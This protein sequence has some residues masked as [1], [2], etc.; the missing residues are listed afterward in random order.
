MSKQSAQDRYVL[1]KYITVVV[2]SN[3]H[4]VTPHW[5]RRCKHLA[6]NCFPECRGHESNLRLFDEANDNTAESPGMLSCASD[7]ATFG[8]KFLCLMF[9][10]YYFE[11]FGWLVFCHL[12]PESTITNSVKS[13]TSEPPMSSE[14]K[15]CASPQSSFN[16]AC[17]HHR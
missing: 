15:R 9:S 3:R 12:L 5:T 14:T 8:S 6:H 10:C 17:H 4:T 2:C 7:D 1:Y 13:P 16:L 11:R